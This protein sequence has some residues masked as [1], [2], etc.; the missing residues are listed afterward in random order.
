MI[1]IKH[2][3]I[4]VLYQTLLLSYIIKF[5]VQLV[6]CEY[7]NYLNNKQKEFINIFNKRLDNPNIEIKFSILNYLVRKEFKSY[8]KPNGHNDD[9]AMMNPSM[10]G[11]K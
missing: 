2:L 1:E 4:I 5:F 3:K 8:S 9:C 11:S 10:N 7:W 6:G